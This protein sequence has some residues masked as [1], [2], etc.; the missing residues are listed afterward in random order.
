MAL[1]VRG[2]IGRVAYGVGFCAVLPVVLAAWASRLEVGVPA[3]Q[4]LWI[5]GAV[6]GMGLVMMVWAMA[7]LTLRG[8]GLPMNAFPPQKLVAT[9]IYALVPHPIYLGFVLASAGVSV[10]AGSAA[11]LWVVTP[12]VALAAGAVVWGYEREDLR[13]RLGDMPRPVVRL[14]EEGGEK[15]TISECVGAIVLVFVPWLVFYDAIPALGLPPDAQDIRLA[16]EKA[17]PVWEYWEPVYSSAYVLVPLSLLW[18]PTRTALRRFGI[19]ALLAIAGVTLIYLVVPIVAPPRMHHAKGV[20]GWM[21][22]WEQLLSKPYVAAF[23]SFHALWGFL[24][25]DL[26]TRRGRAW[27]AATWVWAVA[28]AAS[29]VTT[30]QHAIADILAAGVVFVLL[31]N[32][33]MVYGWLLRGTE[34]LANSWHA[35]RVGPIRIINHGVF[36]AM[37]AFVGVL[38]A[39]WLSGEL[40]WALVIA[41]CGLVTSAIW[42]QTVEGSPTLLRPFGYYGFVVGG[43]LAVVICYACGGPTMLLFAAAATMAPWV[44]A[45]GRLRCLVQGCCHGR[46][47]AAQWGIRVREEH[48]RV[49]RVERLRGVPIHPTQ[50]YSILGNVIIGLLLARLWSLAA[51]LPLITGLY[52]MLGGMARFVEE[53]YRGEPQTPTFGKLAIYHWMA[54]FCVA[55]GVAVTCIHGTAALTPTAPAP[56]AFLAATAAGVVF[57]LAMAVDIPDSRRRFAR[58]SG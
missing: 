45:L 14:P 58:L 12:L 54:M 18:A 48:S 16:L 47:V 6:A 37:G 11:G 31:R 29:C 23:P 25:A 57:W 51:P 44:Q 50:L 4:S 30:G 1:T 13:Q 5:G 36:P 20:L 15:P 35:W 26:M 52:L 10:M 46:E 17:W 3:L 7:L 42:A 53:T 43:L 24:V 38:G 28:V 22:D 41:A 9:G 19:Q 21:L 32:Y 8:D 39:V 40:G 27:G 33:E 2:V 49:S 34:R 55:L 56:V